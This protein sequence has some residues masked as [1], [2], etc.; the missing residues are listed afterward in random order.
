M[1]YCLHGPVTVRVCIADSEQTREL[2][3][4]E[5]CWCRCAQDSSAAAQRTLPELQQVGSLPHLPAVNLNSFAGSGMQD[6]VDALPAVAPTTAVQQY[7]DTAQVGH[8][9]ALFLMLYK[10]M[11]HVAGALP[12]SACMCAVAAHTACSCR[13]CC[14]LSAGSCCGPPR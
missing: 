13:V 7:A 10:S 14:Y 6:T 5:S 1:W 9:Y 3:P 8:L 4:T 11:D 12:R 2:P